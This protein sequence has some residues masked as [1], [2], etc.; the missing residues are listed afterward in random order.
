MMI[1]MKNALPFLLFCALTLCP[2][3]AISAEEPGTQNEQSANL[4]FVSHIRIGLNGDKVIIT[5]EGS[6]EAPGTVFIYRAGQ[7]INDTSFAAAT[8]IGSCP[9]ANGYFEDTPPA[10]TD[11]FYAVLI[12][13]DE[14]TAAQTFIPYK[15]ATA[16]AIRTKAAPKEEVGDRLSISARNEKDYIQIHV[17]SSLGG[18]KLLVYRS[19]DKIASA[20]DILNATLVYVGDEKDKEFSDFPIPGIYYYYTI[21]SEKNLKTGNLKIVPGLSSIEKP[22]MIPAGKFRVGLPSFSANSRAMPLPYL[23]VQNDNQIFSQQNQSSL[24]FPEPQRVKIETQKSIDG[25]LGRLSTT[26]TETPSFAVLAKE[27]S[28]PETGEEY[29]LAEIVGAATKYQNWSDT[30]YSLENFLS[31][32]RSE[33]V[34]SHARYYLGQA[35]FFNKQYREALFNLLL[36]QDD[37]YSESK[38]LISLSLERLREAETD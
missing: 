25:I 29:T 9:E 20:R 10:N 11:V 27:Q 15:N 6:A 28:R 4:R 35:Y 23:S 24:S 38:S 5:W 19:T 16:I 37:L 34:E 36:V 7:E 12:A 3:S 26:P 14:K 18:S 21:L 32:Y 2:L 22:V 33:T 17:T 31:L 8:R 13:K 30:V 1:A